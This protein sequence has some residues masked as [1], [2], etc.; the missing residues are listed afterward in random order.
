MVE[1]ELGA[2]LQI[3]ETGEIQDDKTIMLL[4][5][6]ELKELI[7]WLRLEKRRSSRPGRRFRDIDGLQHICPTHKKRGRPSQ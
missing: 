5:Y 1:V 3:I 4:Q 7:S 2:A 6:A